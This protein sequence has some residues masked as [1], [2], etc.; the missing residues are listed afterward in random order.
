M[1]WYDETR[2]NILEVDT[3]NLQ[4]VEV[5]GDGNGEARARL[6]EGTFST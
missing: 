1:S 3:T 5:I 4:Q 6:F 2:S